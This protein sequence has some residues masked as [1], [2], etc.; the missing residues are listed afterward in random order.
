[1]ATEIGIGTA[2]ATEI[3]K[4]KPRRRLMCIIETFDKCNLSSHCTR[5]VRSIATVL[6]G[7]TV[8]CGCVRVLAC[9]RMIRIRMSTVTMTVDV[10]AVGAPADSLVRLRRLCLFIAVPQEE[11]QDRFL[12]SKAAAHI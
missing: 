7:W 6:T 12:T 9:V 3:G 1:M 8:L 4:A 2:T 10:L 5:Y 11:V